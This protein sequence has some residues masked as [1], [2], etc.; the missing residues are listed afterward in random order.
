MKIARSKIKIH[1]TEYLFSH[2]KAPRG[3]G[4]WAFLLERSDDYGVVVA[5]HTL[6]AKPGTYF[7]SKI[8]AIN[9][10]AD[11]GYTDISVLP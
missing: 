1:T 11:H 10:A 3:R 4:S 6:W 8:E 5:E 9:F 2:T 7:E